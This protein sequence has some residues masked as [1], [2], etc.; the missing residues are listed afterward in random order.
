MDKEILGL[1]RT[2]V[3]FRL[4]G[5]QESGWESIC[6]ANKKTWF[7]KRLAP[8]TKTYRNLVKNSEHNVKT[9]KNLVN[10]YKNLVKTNKNHVNTYKHLSKT[11]KEVF[12]SVSGSTCIKRLLGVFRTFISFRLCVVG[13]SK[14][15]AGRA[16]AW[17]IKRPDSKKTPRAPDKN[18][19][20]PCIN[21]RKH[22][23]NV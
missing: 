23:K 18:I 3:S 1:F 16:F 9:Y 20:K 14:K 5:V 11:Y 10:T 22:C 2:F 4:W 7:E 8:Q 17:Q 15:A 19:Q 6:L 12:G 13:G 21:K